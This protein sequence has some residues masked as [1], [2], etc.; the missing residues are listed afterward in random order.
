MF[1][2][3]LRMIGKQWE[4]HRKNGFGSKVL[5]A[6]ELEA[7]RR[8]CQ[9]AMLDTFTFQAPEFYAKVGYGVFGRL[10]SFAGK[11]N[12]SFERLYFVKELSQGTP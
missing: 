6:A 2:T 8:G 9:Y 4:G 10:D 12:Q 5:A 3:F 1:R 11:D 7:V